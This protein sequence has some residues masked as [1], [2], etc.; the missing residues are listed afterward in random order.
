MESPTEVPESRAHHHSA[1]QHSEGD[2][3]LSRLNDLADGCVGDKSVR[4]DEAVSRR[5]TRLEP[6]RVRP[7]TLTCTH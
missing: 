2:G 3:P 4:R 7:Q 6:I 5:Q 1:L